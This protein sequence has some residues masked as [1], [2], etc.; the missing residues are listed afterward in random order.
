MC[1]IVQKGCI[2]VLVLLWKKK[3]EL[4]SFETAA[5]LDYTLPKGVVLLPI[6]QQ[7]TL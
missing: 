6:K 3:I 2:L 4:S 5:K 7:Q 1:P